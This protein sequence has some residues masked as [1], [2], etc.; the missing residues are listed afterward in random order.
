MWQG[1]TFY[2]TLVGGQDP[3]LVGIDSHVSRRC[4]RHGAHSGRPRW[5]GRAPLAPRRR[6]SVAG[7]EGARMEATE[8]V[9]GHDSHDAPLPIEDRDWSDVF[10]VRRKPDSQKVLHTSFLPSQ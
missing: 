7:V 5:L 1:G 2:P 3:T 8:L 4:L 10:F 6:T 9:G